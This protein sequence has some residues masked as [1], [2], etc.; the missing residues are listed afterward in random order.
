MLL[1]TRVEQAKQPI[2]TKRKKPATQLRLENNNHANKCRRQYIIENLVQFGQIEAR[3][4]HLHAENCYGDHDSEPTHHANTTGG[5]NE[6]QQQID[7]RCQQTDFHQVAH[8]QSLID[9]EKPFDHA[10]HPEVDDDRQGLVDASTAWNMPKA[11]FSPATWCTRA[12]CTQP[13]L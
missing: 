5:T 12:I 8:T 6:T 9:L 1:L 7:E 10:R 2:A 3:D 13:R 4:N 11:A